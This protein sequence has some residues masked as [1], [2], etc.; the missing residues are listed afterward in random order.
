MKNWIFSGLLLM[1]V[2]VMFSQQKVSGVIL[3]N[4]SKMGLPG[5]NVVI[6]NS[7]E[8][9]S[10]DADGK[11]QISTS[12]TS[13]KVV[14]SYIGFETK[15]V[16][17]NVAKGESTNLG[18]IVLGADASELDEIIVVGKGVIDLADSRRTPIAVSTIRASEIKQKTGSADVTQA[19]VNTPSVYVAGQSGGFGDSRITVRGFVKIIPLS[20]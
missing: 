18:K 16:S 1:M 6:Q 2:S 4:D 7:S 3:D 15:T 9:A 20:Y 13:G 8:S 17:F 5:V 10:T 12:A 11:F 19:M 14:I